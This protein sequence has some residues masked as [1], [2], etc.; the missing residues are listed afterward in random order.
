MLTLEAFRYFGSP[1]ART[2]IDYSEMLWG[3]FVLAVGFL[4]ASGYLFMFLAAFFLLTIE[5]RRVGRVLINSFLF[6]AAYM[7]FGLFFSSGFSLFDGALLL[8]G[9]ASVVVSDAIAD[10]ICS[11][12]AGKPCRSRPPPI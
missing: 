6:V 2:A 7:F 5:M 12:L 4:F 8:A 1:F 3:H 11:K 9:I 10:V